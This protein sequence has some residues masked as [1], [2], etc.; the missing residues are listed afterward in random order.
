MRRLS[1][2]LMLVL[3]FVTPA[4]F[5]SRPKASNSEAMA[6]AFDPL[7]RCVA[8]RGNGTHFIAHTAA[9]AKITNRWGEVQ[10]MAGGSSGTITILMYES[11][12]MNPA[13]NFLKGIDRNRAISLLLKSIAGYAQEVMDAPEWKA[14]IAVGTLAGRL[15]AESSLELPPDE[16]KKT[17][18]NLQQI[19]MSDDIRNLINPEIID[20]LD[21]SNSQNPQDYKNKVEEVKKAANSLVNLDASDADVFFRPGLVNFSHFIDLV[22]RIADFYAG[23][24]GSQ[25][26]MAGFIAACGSGTEEKTWKELAPKLT[27]Q[28]TCQVRFSGLVR[29]WRKNR[30]TAA[31]SRLMDEQ[32]SRFRSITVTS[33]V[34]SPATIKVLRQYNTDYLRGAARELNVNFD[35]IGFGYWVSSSFGVDP[36]KLW[37]ESNGDG[38]SKK[39]V[40]LGSAKTWREILEKS[41]REPSLGSYMEFAEGETM[42]GA[43]SLG[44][45]ADLHPVQ[46]LK[47]A[48]CGKV[49]YVTR[50]GQ[51][52]SFI[53]TGAPYNGR[54]QSGLAE[55]LG[56]N[57]S[58]Y[59]DV[60][61][62][63]SPESGFSRALAQADGVWC[64][65]WDRFAASE[66]EGISA[67][68]WSAPLVTRDLSLKQW[69]EADSSGTQIVGCR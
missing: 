68:A 34:T 54:K 30:E 39:A 60:F 25:S 53:S 15:K 46:V 44:G 56:M 18:A 12:L 19:F 29:E 5:P 6:T 4:C 24:G 69:A 41:P 31:K 36:V 8:L 59:N 22:G 33:V 1:R 58:T 26:E 47:A 40:N 28:G 50:R 65:D 27:S 9:L 49:I 2:V 11:I 35:D 45:W 7:E 61:N 16:F 32:G 20:S 38:K 14:L 57:E 64:T 66:Q 23:Y 43:I 13:V 3:L 55:L 42:A 37:R 62:V 67:D 48:G 63:A 52:T 10:A 17:A 21:S 51:E